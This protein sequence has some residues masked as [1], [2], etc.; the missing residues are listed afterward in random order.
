MSLLNLLFNIH[1]VDDRNQVIFCIIVLLAI[2]LIGFFIFIFILGHKNKKK[3]S[4][5]S[6]GKNNIRLF[7]LNYEES[8][9]YVVDKKNF[10]Q[11]RKMDFDWF[12]ESYPREDTLRTKIWLSELINNDRLVNDSIEV[13]VLIGKQKEPMF[14]V[15]T[16]TSIDTKKKIIHLES[17]LFPK[18]VSVK[19]TNKKIDD[20]IMSYNYL[21]NTYHQEKHEKFNVYFLHLFIKNDD[22][23]SDRWTKKIIITTIMSKIKRLLKNS[24]LM[25]ITR[26][27]D[28]IILESSPGNKNKSLAFGHKISQEISK[29]LFL[30]T[31]QNAYSYKIG[32]ATK[33]DAL[34]F[35]ELV[36]SAKEMTLTN[37]ETS[38]KVLFNSITN[39]NNNNNEKF[40]DEIETIIKDKKLSIDYTSLVNCNN[41]HIKGFYTT[42]IPQSNIFNSFREIE[43]YAYSYGLL[44][45]LITMIYKE[46]NSIYTN[47]Y[48]ITSEKRRLF[49]NIKPQ[50]YKN[51]L[52][53][54]KDNKLP[55]NVKNVFVL[56]DKDMVNAAATNNKFLLESL[57]KLKSESNIRLGLE[58]T[59]SSLEMSDDMLR[60]FDYF[61]FNFQDNFPNI[62]TSTHEQI[63]FQDLRDT[64]LSYPNGKLTAVNLTSWQAVEYFSLLGFRYVSS[65]F[66]GKE[67]NKAP[68]IDTRKINKLL[69]LKE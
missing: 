41:G 20:K 14:S 9:V 19:A 65:S 67:T 4:S 7:T 17:H 8:S 49:I 24:M 52:N 28:L 48:F 64:L 25:C 5:F 58:F 59:S 12:F 55:D 31:L 33:K 3:L 21:S 56:N 63:L 46:L 69:S 22:S 32:I 26:N 43:D 29:I 47:K 40:K 50:Y 51:V 57:S 30:N 35:D 66:F 1:S 2:C 15:L 16:C 45:K 62:L 60:L 18:I 13:H 23:I 44:E 36:R 38:S 54:V 11:K 6:S 34:S 61:I 39:T 27:N 10:K 37:D 42:L 68:Q 53:V